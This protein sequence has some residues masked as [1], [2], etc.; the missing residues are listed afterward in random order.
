[1]CCLCRSLH[2]TGL[3]KQLHHRKPAI[4]SNKLSHDKIIMS[5]AKYWTNAQITS[6]W[7]I[8]H[9]MVSTFLSIKH[10]GFSLKIFLWMLGKYYKNWRFYQPVREKIHITIY[11][12]IVMLSV[13][14]HLMSRIWFTSK[15]YNVRLSQ[16]LEGLQNILHNGT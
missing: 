14:S 1:M 16:T 2:S 8:T 3:S 10:G 13:S 9:A 7:W 15:I 11:M 12:L 5:V 4:N 6:D